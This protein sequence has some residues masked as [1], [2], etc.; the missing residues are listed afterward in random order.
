MGEQTDELHGTPGALLHLLQRITPGLLIVSIVLIGCAFALRRP[1]AVI[2][3]LLAGAVLYASVHIQA[4]QAV[5]YAGM[6]VGYGTWIV[7]YLWT[8][9]RKRTCAREAEVQCH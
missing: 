8:R 9:P 1:V 7:L 5:M 3:A 4:D 2:P 6:A